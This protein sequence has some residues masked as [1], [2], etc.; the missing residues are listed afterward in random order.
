MSPQSSIAF[1]YRFIAPNTFGW[2]NENGVTLNSKSN[3]FSVMYS[4]PKIIFIFSGTT[5]SASESF[6]VC[7]IDFIFPSSFN[8][9]SISTKLFLSNSLCVVV[10]ILTIISPVVSA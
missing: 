7:T 1:E 10:T 2:K 9:K 6:S 5:A 3:I 4:C 8:P